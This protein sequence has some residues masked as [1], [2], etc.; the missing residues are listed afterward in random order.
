MAR[1]MTREQKQ[2]ACR[3]DAKGLS[4]KEIAARPELLIAR[5]RSCSF[6]GLSPQC[7]SRRVDTCARSSQRR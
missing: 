5:D 1:H 3:L 7:S 6:G 2:T 4:H